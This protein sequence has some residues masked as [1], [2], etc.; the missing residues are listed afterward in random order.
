MK[1]S[2]I[3]IFIIFF[4]VAC[5]NDYKYN[6]KANL[7]ITNNIE[8]ITNDKAKLEF[9]KATKQI[10]RSRF[11]KAKKHLEKAYEYESNNLIIINA[12]ANNETNLGNYDSAINLYE[13]AI[14]NDSTFY[15]T[16]ANYGVLLNS[17]EKYEKAKIIMIKAVTHHNYENLFDSIISYNLA[18]SYIGLKDY[19]NALSFAKR[20]LSYCTNATMRQEIEDL[21][22]HIEKVNEKEN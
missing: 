4:T 1:N 2:L 22:R 17:L 5:N 19:G 11:F 8:K 18:L 7:L 6:K 20:S 13:K 3:S 14:K 16:Y 9:I 21:I 12:F 15:E 10:D